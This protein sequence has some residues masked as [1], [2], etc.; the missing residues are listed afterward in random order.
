MDADNESVWVLTHRKEIHELDANTLASKRNVTVGY[1]AR[2]LALAKV[3]GEV[4]VGD[5]TG[6]IHCLALESLE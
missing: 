1:D 2:S 4:W 6:K 5:K 3:A